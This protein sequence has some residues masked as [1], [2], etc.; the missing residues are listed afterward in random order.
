VVI[1]NFRKNSP[2]L[3]AID[4]S[5]VEHYCPLVDEDLNLNLGHAY[6]LNFVVLVGFIGRW[7]LV[8]L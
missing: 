2:L 8:E 3:E 6:H 1:T 7:A 4:S 5:F